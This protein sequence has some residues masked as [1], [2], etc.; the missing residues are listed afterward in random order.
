MP[1]RPHTGEPS[2]VL[3]SEWAT[4][5]ASPAHRTTLFLTRECI[6][7]EAVK[8]IAS[9]SMAI[10]IHRHIFELTPFL[11]YQ[12]TECVKTAIFNDKTSIPPNDMRPPHH[13]W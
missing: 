10:L 4:T 9:D 8:R 11:F 3:C 1:L 12:F 6:F 5:G 7:K 13:M 2:V